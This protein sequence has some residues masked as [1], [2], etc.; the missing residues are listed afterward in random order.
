MNDHSM[1]KSADA[2][3][4]VWPLGKRERTET[5]FADRLDNLSGKTIAEVW[6]WMWGGDVAFGIIREELK[7]RY[8]DI[9]IIPYTE[10]GNIHG[11]DENA[12][13]AG[14]GDELKRRGVD[15]VILGIANCGSCTP[16]VLR[17]HVAVE[18]AGIP[19]VSIVGRPFVEQAT[20]VAEYLNVA[21]AAMA[22]YPGNI[23][24]DSK[25]LFRE[26]VSDHLPDPIVH[27]LLHGSISA[28][29]AIS[30][31]SAREI[32]FR[33]SLDEVQDYVDAMAW[34]DGLPI[35]PPTLERVEEFLSFTPRKPDEVL[36]RL[37]PAGHEATIWNVAV[38]GVMAGCKPEYMPVL[39][40]AAEII[41]DP[42]FRLEDQGASPAWEMMLTVSGPIGQELDFN[43]RHGVCASGRRAN[44]SIGRFLRLYSR[45]IAGH[46]IPPGVTDYAA[47]G[48]N[49]IVAIAED[50]DKL[51]ELGWPT[52]GED[53][54]LAP[55]ESGVTVQG[56]NAASPTFFYFG[57]NDGDPNTSL[58]PLRDVFGTAICGYWGFTGATYGHWHPLVLLN[59]DMAASIA[60]HG[61]TKDDVRRFLYEGC[62][63][64][65]REMER[66]GAVM[67]LD[68]A[69]QVKRGV[70]P[71]TYHESDDPER[72]VPLFVK[73]EWIGVVVAGAPTTCY[74]GYMNNHEQGVPATRKVELPSDWASRIAAHR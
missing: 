16:A 29:S 43:A 64:T 71:A 2:I 15:A 67:N 50:E 63:I 17:A 72:L 46:R 32:V 11:P 49:F 6:S 53:Q 45:N 39:V 24:A 37:L 27:G 5:V 31:P 14:L 42:A 69:D 44:T 38:N 56:I 73:P 26:R 51:R 33:G 54:G 34:G 7:R 55:G 74:R 62:R 8:P 60:A 22:I 19:A 66:R 20:A 70:L 28:A 12:V 52:Y 36:A 9:T 68:L 3:E 1:I 41:C 57:G 30:D 13:M 4:I 23:E 40:A 59:P 47:V 18:R 21:G 48:N 61:W 10:F 35:V 65:A 25:E 58:A